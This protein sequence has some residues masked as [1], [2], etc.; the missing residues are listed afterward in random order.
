MRYHLS[1][2]PAL[3]RTS[4]PA[5]FWTNR[6]RPTSR[7]SAKAITSAQAQKLE[8]CGLLGAMGGVHVALSGG[9]GTSEVLIPVPQL[10]G[11]Q[12]PVTYAISV[13]PPETLV[14][15]R[16]CEREGSNRMA[17][18]R[19]KGAPGQKIQITWSSIVLISCNAGSRT[20]TVRRDLIK[21]RVFWSRGDKVRIRK[22]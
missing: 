1:C 5:L 17:R 3:R 12:V 19:V 7:A 2:R 13:T 16:L 6:R 15:C 9:R 10:D 14:E 21:R 11:H 20:P 22:L 8:G 4:R 18:V